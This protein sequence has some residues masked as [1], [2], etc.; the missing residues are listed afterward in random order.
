MAAAYMSISMPP[1]DPEPKAKEPPGACP[2]S[3]PVTAL[4]G[5][6]R[7]RRG[8]TTAVKAPPGLSAPSAAAASHIPPP[9]LSGAGPAQ[10]PA[11]TPSPPWG[12]MH[13]LMRGERSLRLSGWLRVGVP[14]ISPSDRLA[15]ASSSPSIPPEPA[16]VLWARRGE[17]PLDH[18]TLSLGAMSWSPPLAAAALTLIPPAP[19][20]DSEPPSPLTSRPGSPRARKPALLRAAFSLPTRR[21]ALE[22]GSVISPSRVFLMDSSLRVESATEASTAGVSSALM[23]LSSFFTFRYGHR[24][25]PCSR[26]RCFRTVTH[27]P[28]FAATSLIGRW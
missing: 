14:G 15:A 7:I 28:S 5:T 16:E 8:P 27:S 19:P 22:L 21:C 9:W 13:P 4:C 23:M 12:A 20:P 18:A 17:P 26:Q 24:V 11:P 3:A 25:M 6:G 2:S 1:N 10:A